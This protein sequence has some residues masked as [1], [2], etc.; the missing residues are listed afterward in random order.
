VSTQIAIRLGA[1]ELNA[2]DEEVKAGRAASRSDAVRRAIGYLSREQRYRHE[3][4]T[5][6]VLA[7]RGEPVHPDLEGILDLPHPRLD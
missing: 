6:L 7:K 1:D 3:D 2:L 5:L 4:A